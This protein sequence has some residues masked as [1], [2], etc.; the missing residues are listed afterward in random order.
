[1][2]GDLGGQPLVLPCCRSST[3]AQANENWAL[4]GTPK[5]LLLAQHIKTRILVFDYKVLK[6]LI[7]QYAIFCAHLISVAV[8]MCT[9]FNHSFGVL[10]VP[11]FHLPAPLY[12]QISWN[13]TIFHNI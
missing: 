1:M 11:S 4:S 8:V 3:K 12:T 5:T 13:L 2:P 7:N 6:K 9:F 10:K